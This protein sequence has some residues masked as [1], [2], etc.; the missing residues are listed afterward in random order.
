MKDGNLLAKTHY[1]GLHGLEKCKNL[2]HYVGNADCRFFWFSDV[3]F[4]MAFKDCDMSDLSTR[5][6][7]GT[8]YHW[9]EG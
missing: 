4:C 6:N 2:C 7:N 1:K 9:F 5:P 3:N 8:T